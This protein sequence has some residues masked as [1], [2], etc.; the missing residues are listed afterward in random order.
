M[1]EKYKR[2]LAE[3]FV[4]SREIEQTSLFKQ[5]LGQE[6]EIHVQFIQKCEEIRRIY[7][8]LDCVFQL[9]QEGDTLATQKWLEIQEIL[10]YDL[11]EGDFSGKI[12]LEEKNKL[13]QAL[14]L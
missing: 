6:N 9:S 2:L 13:M 1:E 3:R 5:L 7:Q 10:E 11:F 12:G 8:K 4:G 14:Q